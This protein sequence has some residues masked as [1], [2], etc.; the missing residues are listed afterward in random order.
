MPGIPKIVY[1]KLLRSELLD[2]LCQFGRLLLPLLDLFLQPGRVFVCSLRHLTTPL[3]RSKDLG[4]LSDSRRINVAL[5][6]PET[7]ELF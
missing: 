3:R 2:L 5:P 6:E 4:F 1:I 7:V